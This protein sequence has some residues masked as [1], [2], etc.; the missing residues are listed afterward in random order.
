MR[1]PSHTRHPLDPEHDGK[2][3]HSTK[4][5]LCLLL[6]LDEQVLLFKGPNPLQSTQWNPSPPSPFHWML[7]PYFS[8]FLSTFPGLTNETKDFRMSC[9]NLHEENHLMKQSFHRASSGVGVI[10]RVVIL[11]RFTGTLCC[12]PLQEQLEMIYI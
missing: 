9:G 10:Y 3:P 1:C 5:E 6:I 12:A 2:H 7:S 11:A 8:P 4:I